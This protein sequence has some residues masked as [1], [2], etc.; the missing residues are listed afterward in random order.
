MKVSLEGEI[1]VEIDGEMRSLEGVI[2]GCPLA[3]AMFAVALQPHLRWADLQLQQYGGVARAG[4]DEIYLVGPAEQTLALAE[5]FAARVRPVQGSGLGLDVQ[6]RK[7]EYYC[8]T[9]GTTA[10]A[11]RW[12]AAH[13]DPDRRPTDKDPVVSGTTCYGVPIGDRGFVRRALSVKATQVAAAIE[14]T[15]EVLGDERQAL[16]HVIRLSSACKFDYW[17]QLNYPTDVVA[18]AQVVDAAL[19][20]AME[21]CL[22][23]AVPQ[24]RCVPSRRVR[25]PVIHRGLGLREQG[26]IAPMAFLGGLEQA[27]PHFGGLPLDPPPLKVLP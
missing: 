5:E 11:R 9:A 8:P 7:S 12:I 27:L 10:A 3:M 16:W 18:A 15:M 22:G 26:D 13:P 14:E 23:F 19:W 20:P 25:L 6:R 17:L 1:W 4:A 2:Q 24:E 21:S